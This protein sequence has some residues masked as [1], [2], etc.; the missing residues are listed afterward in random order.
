MHTP[1]FTLT[2]VISP[3]VHSVVTQETKLTELTLQDL[4]ETGLYIQ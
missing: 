4:S 1:R 2:N 3:V